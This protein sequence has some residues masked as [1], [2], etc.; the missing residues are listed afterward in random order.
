MASAVEMMSDSGWPDMPNKHIVMLS[1]F[2]ATAAA[3]IGQEGS[4]ATESE[5]P[6]ETPAAAST[7]DT[8]DE[9]SDEVQTQALESTSTQ[10]SNA[11]EP[12]MSSGETNSAADRYRPTER[13][14]EDRS[15]SFPIDI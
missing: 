14:S 2:L 13:I 6:V 8:D 7:N 10:D 3:A 9:I 4:P 5:S 15:V 11:T 12:E 1:I